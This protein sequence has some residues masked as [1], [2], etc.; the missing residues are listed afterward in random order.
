MGRAKFLSEASLLGDIY[1]NNN[2]ANNNEAN[3]NE[4][5]NNEANNLMRHT[6]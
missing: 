6:T 3:N 1:A 5:N 2:E 4:A